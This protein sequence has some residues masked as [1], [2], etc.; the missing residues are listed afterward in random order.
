M[1]DEF[2]MIFKF[3]IAKQTIENS[4]K[5]NFFPVTGIEPFKILVF[6]IAFAIV[7]FQLG[8]IF[9]KT[10]VTV[11]FLFLQFLVGQKGMSEAARVNVDAIVFQMIIQFKLCHKT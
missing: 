8:G 10:L 9:S 11:E 1:F 4:C 2:Q 5:I 7:Q 6:R 3:C